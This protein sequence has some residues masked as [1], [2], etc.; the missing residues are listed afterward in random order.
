MSKNQLNEN[1]L[2]LQLKRDYLNFMEQINRQMGYDPNLIGVL[3]ALLMEMEKTYL[4]QDQIIELTGFSRTIVS[5]ALATLTDITSKFPVLETRKPRDKKKYYHS[6]LDFEEYI[7]IIFISSL[8]IINTNV[9][10][11]PPL[12]HRLDALT[13]QNSYILHVKQLLSLF[14][15]INKS[16]SA[17]VEH[18]EKNLKRILENT[19]NNKD[20]LNQLIK[21]ESNIGISENRASFNENIVQIND[22]FEKIKKEYITKMQEVATSMGRRKELI[23]I[24]LSLYLEK[25]PITQDNLIQLTNYSRSTISE[26]LTLLSKL[27][28]VE[29]V[30]KPK[31]RKKY[32][33]PRINM[34]EYGLLGFQNRKSLF[35]KIK[36]MIE[37]TF[38]HELKKIIAPNIEKAKLELFFKENIRCYQILEDYMTVFFNYF[39]QNG[40]L[41]EF[42]A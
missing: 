14:N 42:P 11:I 5:D 2:F 40:R 10:F 16:L 21:N 32:Y 15:N 18:S 36:T 22:S 23:A 12:I 20:I 7:R 34:E 39:Y 3:F 13:P 25:D 24:F 30:K 41:K 9:E 31:D 38:L 27:N 19:D 8:E 28:T 17:F 26:G 29:V 4:T 35:S 33:K 1:D 37:N 6:P